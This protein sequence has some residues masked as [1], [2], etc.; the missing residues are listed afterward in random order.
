[1]AVSSVG[2]LGDGMTHGSDVS[3]WNIV[4][5]QPSIVTTCRSAPIAKC[6][7]NSLASSPTVI[8]WRIGIGYCPTNDA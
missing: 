4:R 6:S 7:L 5:V 1:M 3:S 2:M 8:P